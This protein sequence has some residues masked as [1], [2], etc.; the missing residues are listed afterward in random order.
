MTNLMKTDPTLRCDSTVQTIDDIKAILAKVTFVN[1]RL[2]WGW[3]F[4]VRP[5]GQDDN[6][7]PVWVIWAQ[8]NRPDTKTGEMGIGRGR[9]EIVYHGQSESG[10]AKTCWLLVELL[11]RHELMEGFRYE[12]M[13]IFDPHNTI[14]DLQLAQTIGSRGDM[15][16]TYMDQQA[17][18]ESKSESD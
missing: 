10:V 5:I 15:A 9:D 13:R 18:A 4:H 12:D 16:C 17:T 11:V 3:T 2:D 6:G 8:F 1:T 14:G 7:K